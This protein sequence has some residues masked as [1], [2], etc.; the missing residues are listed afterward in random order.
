MSRIVISDIHGCNDTLM[1]LIAQLPPGIPLT[2][3]G[4][5]IDRGPNSRAIVDYVKAS[6]HDAVVGN[7]EVMMF[8]DLKFR[9]RQDGTEQIHIDRDSD[10]LYNGGMK[11]LRNYIILETGE[12]DYKALK[13]HLE[14]MKSLPY[15]IEYPDLKNDKGQH[16][17]VTHTTASHVWEDFSP[18]S[19]IFQNAVTWDRNAMPPKIDGI[20]NVYGHTPQ[21]FKATIK[22]H[23]ACIDTGACYTT[24]DYGTL[25]ALQWPEMITYTQK[26]IEK[27]PK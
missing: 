27:E 12:Y 17:L 24:H 3:A 25:T 6:G 15:Y 11:C 19:A 23:F 8:T 10:W 20:F 5:L 7:H 13:E 9:L 16:L 14:W 21:K 1:A 4:D 22:E 2:F 18:E 26:N